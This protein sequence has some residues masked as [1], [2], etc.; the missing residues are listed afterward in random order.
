M[1][2]PLLLTLITHPTQVSS[3]QTDQRL[4]GIPF[5]QVHIQDRFWTPRQ[6]ANRKASVIHCLEELQST[7]DVNNF[8][9][10]AEGGRTGRKGF[11]FQ[12]SDVY[13][14]IEG[15]ADTLATHP[16]P[17]LDHK[18]DEIIGLIGKAQMPDG[19]VNTYYQVV[20]PGKRFTNLRD[21]HELYCAGHLF[22]AATAHFEATG[23]RNLLNIA[24]RYADLLV[25]RYGSKSGR[26]GYG[27]H[28]ELELALVKLSH[29]T[30]NKSYFALAEKLVKTRGNHFFAKEHQTPEADYDGTYWIDDVPISAHK[31]IKGHAVRA[32]YLMSGT[33]DII[34]E[35][36]DASIEKMLDRVWN[37]AVN[38]RVFVTGGIG[39]SGS[40]EGFTVDYDLPN[41]TAYQE[42]CASVAMAMWGYRMGMLHEKAQYFDAVENAL[43]NAMLAGVSLD[44]NRFFYVNP[45]ASQGNHHR[46]PWFD[47]ACCPP[48]VLRTVATLGG[49]AYGQKAND[50]FVNLYLPGSVDLKVGGKSVHLDVK[51]DYPWNGKIQI[52]PVVKT[53]MQMGFNLRIPG[54]CVNA[55]LSINGRKEDKPKVVNG[56]FVVDRNWNKGDTIEVNLPMPISRVEANPLVKEDIGKLAV[57]RGPLIYCAEA[58]DQTSPL[59][60]I[61]IQRDAKLTQEWQPKLL[62]GIMAIRGL[63]QKVVATDWDRKLYQNAAPM[64]ATDVSL[65][66]YCYWDNR[67]AGQMEIWLPSTP[68]ASKAGGLEVRAK[69]GA[70]YVSSNC[71]PDGINNGDEPKSSSDQPTRLM[72]FWP[73]KGTEEWVSYSWKKPA[74]ISGI[75]VYWFDDT[76]RGECRIPKSWRL[77]SLEGNKWVPVKADAY[78]VKKDQWCEVKFPTIKTTALRLVVQMQTGWAAGVRQWKIE[79]DDE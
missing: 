38:K 5:R 74:P 31:E 43:Y 34:R 29:V 56:Y 59:N 68:P 11:V 42:T 67:K 21:N 39:P 3:T 33:T 46:Q 37:N 24:T 54:W 65:V 12:D 45:L 9:I 75:K 72:H 14:V 58:T 47:C 28:P 50:I 16:D 23:K 27:G 48:N 44:G 77:E 26:L 63:A 71:Q 1:I 62:G 61:V 8:K 18:L 20:E 25:A 2:Y 51:G 69:V 60:E 66:P 7:G 4:V 53:P 32:A 73:H 19:Y 13:K 64:V 76:G 41:L 36:H 57:R 79:E 40:N 17:D 78:P 55:S 15:A 6:E 49:Y 35:D 30:G 70:S 22:E 10:A 52:K